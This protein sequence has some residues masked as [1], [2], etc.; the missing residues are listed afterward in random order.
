MLNEYEV[1]DRIAELATKFGCELKKVEDID[2]KLISPFSGFMGLDWDNGIIYYDIRGMK[3]E[4]NKYFCVGLIHELAHAVAC[5]KKP[6]AS[7]EYDF[8]GWEII[9]A[10]KV[11]ISRE[12]WIDGNGDYGVGSGGDSMHEMKQDD[13]EELDSILDERVKY[14]LDNHLLSR[15]EGGGYNLLMVR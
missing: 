11:G 14:A 13:P 2:S 1:L 6:Q 5:E 3:Y 9:A 7:S 15:A 10:D 12:D 4:G 8:L